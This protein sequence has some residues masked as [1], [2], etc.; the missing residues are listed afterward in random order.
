MIIQQLENFQPIGL[1]EIRENQIISGSFPDF[2][3]STMQDAIQSGRLEKAASYYCQGISN[4]YS[5]REGS[6]LAIVGDD[7]TLDADDE[8][9]LTDQI[10]DRA[11]KPTEAAIATWVKT[12]KSQMN[13][14]TKEG[15]SLTEVRDRIP[16]LYSTLKSDA[17]AKSLNQAM[18][19]GYLGGRSE[20]LDELAANGNA[21]EETQ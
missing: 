14:W 8:P 7:L 10:T 4:L 9:D 19:L 1:I 3:E 15:L 20:I 16:Q 13:T 12:L 6:G 5:L 11:L 18:Q 21:E 2:L 17:F